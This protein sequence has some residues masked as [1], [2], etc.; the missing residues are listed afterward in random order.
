MA[1]MGER[2]SAFVDKLVHIGRVAKVVKGGRRFAFT[3]IVVV[4]DENG[5]VGWGSGKAKEVPEAVRKATD[6]AKKGMFRV[7]MREG[8]TIHHDVIGHFGAAKVVMKPATPGTGIIAGGPIRAIFE[9]MGMKD[10]VTKSQGSN[11]P[12]NMIQATFDAFEQMQTPRHIAAKRGLKMSDLR[13]RRGDQDEKEVAEG[14]EQKPAPKKAAPAK[15]AAP[16]KAPAKKAAPAKSAAP[17]KA[18]TEEAK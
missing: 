3:A 7:A 14:T 8:R 16:K 5:R 18:E 17:E 15:K 2:D 11:N 4:G 9:A 12:Y 13:T 1:F 6:A 10:V